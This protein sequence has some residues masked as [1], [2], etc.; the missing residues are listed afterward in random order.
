MNRFGEI[1]SMLL[2]LQLAYVSYVGPI[3][4]STT[5]ACLYSFH[6][7]VGGSKK[8][9]ANNRRNLMRVVWHS[10]AWMKGVYKTFHDERLC[11]EQRPSVSISP[12][13]LSVINKVSM[14]RLVRARVQGR[15]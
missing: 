7:T 5:P 13:V 15:R 9:N 14:L 1:A 4:N 2:C 3:Q 12:F 11:E 10:I 6:G 8:D